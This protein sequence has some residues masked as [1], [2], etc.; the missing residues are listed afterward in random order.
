[1][2]QNNKKNLLKLLAEV[3]AEFKSFKSL[4][5][6]L[7]IYTAIVKNNEIE[8]EGHS[9]SYKK[10]SGLIRSYFE[11]L[12]RL[13]LFKPSD[14]RSS[15]GVGAGATLDFAKKSAIQELI[16][17]HLLLTAWES[18]NSWVSHELKS[19]WVKINVSYLRK[20]G[21]RLKF[22]R[23]LT[24]SGVM[25]CG[26]SQHV[27]E[28]SVFD[29]VFSLETQKISFLE[30]KLLFSI[31]RMLSI[32]MKAISD[33]S[34]ASRLIDHMRY[35]RNPQRNS[36]F[37]FIKNSEKKVISVKTLV[38]NIECKLLN[39]HLSLAY[40]VHAKSAQM[41]EFKWGLKSLGSNNCFPHPLG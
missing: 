5:P 36:V 16:E 32:P 34:E 2:F 1:M 3:P 6:G 14:L 29:C 38:P 26:L 9:E 21:W 41:L 8:V 35:Y 37:D 10:S 27:Q 11:A 18:K 17:R 39:K 13:A 4:L 40:V 24:D 22:Y 28:G 25:L 15:N 33:L 31:T 23:I 12:E 7:K 30:R 19:L 20:L